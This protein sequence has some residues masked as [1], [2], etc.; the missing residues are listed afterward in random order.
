MLLLPTSYLPPIRDIGIYPLK[1]LNDALYYLRQIYNPEVR[2][3][4]RRRPHSL[5]NALSVPDNAPRIS[6]ELDTLRTDAFERSYAIKWLTALISQL[7]NNNSYPD[8]SPTQ[9]DLQ[10]STEDLMQSAASLLAICAGTASAGVTVRQFVFENAEDDT[11]LLLIKVELVD[12]PLD[13]HDYRSMG[14]QTWGSACIMAEMI[15]EHPTQFGFHQPQPHLCRKDDAEPSTF[16][17]LELGAGTGLV[18]L[19]IAK[20]MQKSLLSMKTKLEVIATDYYPSVLTNLK[21]NISSNFPSESSS[22]ASRLRILTQALDWSTFSSETTHEP[23]FE[24][25]FDLILGADIVY[26]PQHAP[27]IKSCL[28]KLLRKPSS[29]TTITLSSDIKQPTFHLVIPLRTTHT[30]ESDSIEQIF[31]FN[32]HERSNSNGNSTELVIKHK[33]IVVCDAENGK[34]GEDVEYAYYKI[35]WGC[36]P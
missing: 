7:G 4:R 15:V 25:P 32:N 21:R 28:T 6:R 34:E 18:S 20:M 3:S 22:S 30:L 14:A 8:S 10:P 24:T 36:V 33:D 35:G 5:T 31:P 16:R 17:C 1:T 2:G 9:E 26:E 27:W 12:A 23:V 13:N 19:T 29:T 11:D